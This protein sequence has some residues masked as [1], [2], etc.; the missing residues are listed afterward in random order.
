MT[1]LAALISELRTVSLV[2]RPGN[3]HGID[4]DDLIATVTRLEQEADKISESKRLLTNTRN[5]L[6]Q[7]SEV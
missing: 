2:A 3:L 4:I 7:L 5:R 1:K 6:R